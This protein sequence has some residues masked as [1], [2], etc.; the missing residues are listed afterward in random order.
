MTTNRQTLASHGNVARAADQAARHSYS[1]LI[2]YLSCRTGD[3]ASAE[4]ALADAFERAMHS[5]GKTGIP[6]HPEAWLLA[7]ARNRLIDEGRRKS[8]RKSAEPTLQL[9]YEEA[10]FGKTQKASFPDDRLKLLFVCAHPA[11]D[12]TAR[13]PLM[14]QSV[15]GLDAKRIASAFLVSPS[16]M[17][18]RLVRAKNK[19]RAS[20]IRFAVPDRSTLSD[21]LQS[22]LESIYAAFGTGWDDISGSDHR[23]SDLTEEALW[24]A[25]LVVELMPEQ[26][27]TK[28][29][30]ALMLY[31]DSRRGAR[32]SPTDAY[33]ALSEQDTS[34]WSRPMVAEAEHQLTE[35]LGQRQLGPFQ[36]EA[37]I[38]S[39]HCMRLT[40]GR[41]N[42]QDIVDIY[43]RLA[44]MAPTAGVLIGRAAALAE[45]AGP[46]A[47][48]E[49]LAALEGK[50][51]Q[52]YQPYWAVRAD[53]M[54]R[55]G[56][57][58]E[59]HA[60]YDMAIGLCED[61]AIRSYLTMKQNR[62]VS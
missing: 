19:I 12:I 60:A 53:L 22:V 57:T 55:C 49:A 25:R 30:L 42:W 37:S 4:D 52:S 2:A 50:A 24:L 45:V 40:T 16:T 20:A 39:A 62:D 21:R 44:K 32:R 26:P 59:A 14:L 41:N 38:Q 28:G 58:T 54:S 43:D 27:E 10:D 48:L 5:W 3:V 6:D 33:V 8:V 17:S 61:P 31:C 7:T 9:I 18:Q 36:L 1:R 34:L 51:T 23:G 13:T 46:A 11:I 35:A 47:G 56:H 29:L 15:L